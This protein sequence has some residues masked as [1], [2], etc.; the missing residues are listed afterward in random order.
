MNHNYKILVLGVCMA[1]ECELGCGADFEPGSRVESPRILAL[2]ADKPF[3]K[4]GEDVSLTLLAANPHD[5]P[6]EW[7]WATCTLPPSSTVDDCIEALDTDLERF[8]PET[9]A[10]RVSVPDDVLDGVPQAA[11]ASALIGVVVLACPGELK[12]GQTLGVPTRCVDEQGVTRS[13]DDLEVG[14]KRIMLRERDR[15]ENPLIEAITWDGKTWDEDEVQEAVLCEKDTVLF[16]D[17]SE[18]LQHSIGVTTTAREAGRDENGGDF[19][20]QVIVQL[21]STHGLFRD[22]VRIAEDANT[23]WVAQPQPGSD[24]DLATLWFIARDDRGGVSWTTREVMLR[25]AE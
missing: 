4:P 7:A 23:K 2:Q 18:S 16:D 14:I 11:R 1:A 12:S 5:E 3:A 19:T 25:E 21:Y 22:Q 8:D 15:N 10:L 17:C 24:N 6:L 13:I 20:E 9:D